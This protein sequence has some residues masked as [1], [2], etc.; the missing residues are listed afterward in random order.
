[1]LS[2]FLFQWDQAVSL[3]QRHK[4]SEISEL[5]ARYAAYLL[6]SNRILTAVEL[7]P[8]HVLQN[9][10]FCSDLHFC[11]S[12]YQL[13]SKPHNAV[14]LIIHSFTHSCTAIARQIALL[15][16]PSS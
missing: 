6:D 11:Y 13:C 16:Q 7:Y 10:L 2:S 4:L 1:M 5:L 14:S 8:Y 9:L 15:M 3:A 12:S